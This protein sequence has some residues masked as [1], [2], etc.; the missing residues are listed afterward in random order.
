MLRHFLC[1]G[2]YGRVHCIKRTAIFLSFHMTSVFWHKVNWGHSYLPLRYSSIYMFCQRKLANSDINNDTTYSIALM[3]S[4]KDLQLW[5]DASLESLMQGLH[6]E[7]LWTGM[8]CGAKSFTDT[9]ESTY[10][11]VKYCKSTKGAPRQE[12]VKRDPTPWGRVAHTRVHSI[13]QATKQLRS[14]YEVLCRSLPDSQIER[15]YQKM[16]LA[17]KESFRRKMAEIDEADA[18]N[19][20]SPPIRSNARIDNSYIKR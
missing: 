8:L 6:F 13:H 16:T 3:K 17:E 12:R 2:F 18:A 19:R 15:A 11:T 5:V 7:S 10:I 14:S 1:P 20:Q 9:Y 4:N